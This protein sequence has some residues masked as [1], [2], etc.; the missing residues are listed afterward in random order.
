V[1]DLHCHVLPGID[2]GPAT[3]EESVELARAA[4]A[5]GVR[6]MVAT[7]HVNWRYRNASETIAA[8]TAQLNARLTSEG[9]Q[10]EV[11]AGAEIALTCVEEISAQ[12]LR[13]LRLGDGPWLLIEPPF[14]PFAAGL[15]GMVADVCRQSD[16]IVLAHPE[17]SPTFHRD[18][19]MLGSLVS[20]GALT[21]ITA[22]SL[23]GRFGR[24]VRR[25]ALRMVSEGVVHNVSS[26]AHNLTG[27]PPGIAE[28]IRL[29]G[30]APLERWLTAEVP[31]AI[32]RGEP[33]PARPDVRLPALEGSRWRRR[34]RR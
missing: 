24:D 23:T 19:R 25:F 14:T 26:D 29:V 31:A 5:D 8:L 4:A 16:G 28:E 34:L 22:S 2:D 30:M 10:V 13:S 20:R 15:E 17:R 18:P 3:I 32:L 11:Q 27:R 9:V 21:S 12:E 33:I 7:P 6:T 1:I